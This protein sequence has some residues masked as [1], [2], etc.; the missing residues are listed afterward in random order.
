M[1]AVKQ[2][3]ALEAFVANALVHSAI[4]V[5]QTNLRSDVAP[6]VNSTCVVMPLMMESHDSLPCMSYTHGPLT[7]NLTS[8]YRYRTR[9][10]AA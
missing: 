1:R 3:P 7:T 4:L 10:N 9:R 2:F 8:R 6:L 5:V